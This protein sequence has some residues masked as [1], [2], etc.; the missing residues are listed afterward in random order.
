MGLCE[1]KAFK[2]ARE[3]IPLQPFLVCLVGVFCL[4]SVLFV[5]GGIAPAGATK[6]LSARPLETFGIAFLPGG[7]KRGVALDVQDIRPA[8]PRKR[9]RAGF[10]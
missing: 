6:G 2:V 10:L 5:A 7:L 9:G 1:H 4:V 3:E 8:L